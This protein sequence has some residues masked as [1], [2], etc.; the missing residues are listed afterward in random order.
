MQEYW[1]GLPFPSPED[2]P[3]PGVKH[4]SLI[5]QADSLYTLILAF[6][7]KPDDP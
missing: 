3:D 1:S 2:L 7:D 6:G 5:L 4:G